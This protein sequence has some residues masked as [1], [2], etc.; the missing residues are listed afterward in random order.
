[1][2]LEISAHD[3]YLNIKR[4]NKNIDIVINMLITLVKYLKI[5]ESDRDK[6]LE[7]TD[8]VLM[9]LNEELNYEK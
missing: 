2:D 3:L 4:N 1:M 7:Y 6:L 8:F 9:V 5:E